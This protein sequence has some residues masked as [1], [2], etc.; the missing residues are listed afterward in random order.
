MEGKFELQNITYHYTSNRYQGL[1][2]ILGKDVARVYLNDEYQQLFG[3]TAFY[4]AWLQHDKKGLVLVIMLEDYDT[5]WNLEAFYFCPH[6]KTT[7]NGDKVLFSQLMSR[8]ERSY[9]RGLG[10]NVLRL[11]LRHMINTNP[12]VNNETPITLGATDVKALD[13]GN[14]LNLVKF[15]YG[16]SFEIDYEEYNVYMNQKGYQ[17]QVSPSTA[18]YEIENIGNEGF[19]KF[20]PMISTFGNVINHQ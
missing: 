20:V 2:F 5:S 19:L 16:L 14:V 1:D 8:S 6:L 9:F 10:A 12:N 7:T 11:L 17:R 4:N 13:S 18:R 3:P 15:Y